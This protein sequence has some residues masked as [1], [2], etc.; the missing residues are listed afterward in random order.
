MSEPASSVNNE[1]YKNICSLER[2]SALAQAAR[3]VL[4][5]ADKLIEA[6][7][8]A[9]DPVGLRLRIMELAADIANAPAPGVLP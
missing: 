1:F 8:S 2:S 5:R 3:M 6:A 9:K 4:N 7:S